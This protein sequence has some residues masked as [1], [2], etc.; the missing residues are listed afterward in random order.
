MFIVCLI[1]GLV[2]YSPRY[3]L[4]P[5]WLCEVLVLRFQLGDISVLGRDVVLRVLICCSSP[6]LLFI[7]TFFKHPFTGSDV[8]SLPPLPLHKF[9]GG[10]KERRHMIPQNC[11]LFIPHWLFSCFRNCFAVPWMVVASFSPP[12]THTHTY[13]MEA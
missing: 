1:Q 4:L 2:N 6:S 5:V 13:H 9:G 10:G 8:V 7:T 12:H 11:S 3:C